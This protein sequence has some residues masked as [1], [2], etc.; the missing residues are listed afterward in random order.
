VLDGVAIIVGMVI[1]AGIFKTPSLV[2][3]NCASVSEVLFLWLAGG[4]FCLVG[5]LCYAELTSAYPHPGGDYH[6]LGRAF[7][8]VPAFLFAWSRIT[9]IQTGSIAMLAFLIGDYASEMG[10]L[11]PYSS[12][13]YAAITIIVLTGLNLLGIQ[14]GR[15]M[16]NLLTGAIVLG[17][18]TVVALGLLG[19]PGETVA[20]SAAPTAGGMTAG[21]VGKA[22]IFVLL[23]Y[24]GW[25]EIAYLSSEVRRARRNMVR[26]L[27]YGIA[28]ITAVYF[29]VNYV[30]F[31]A[32]GLQAVAASEAVAV[33]LVRAAL[34]ES[35]VSFISVLVIIAAL[36]TMNAVIITGSRTNYAFGRD[37]AFF[38]FLGRWHGKAN[39]PVN[40]LIFQGVA[41]LM[42]VV[43]G[44]G[45]R[46]GF[47]MMVEY[48]APVFWLFFF[49]VGMCLFVLRKKERAIVRPF[50]VPLYPLTPLIFCGVSLF[51]FYSSVA[52]TGKGG[53]MSLAVL[54]AGVPFLFVRRPEAEFG[55][56]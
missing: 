43:L 48:T 52:F 10:R 31:E 54:L 11:G 27:L 53:I 35:A 47:A 23:T 44:T 25:N 17:L 13:L 30:F 36:S 49:L 41:A 16:Q 2:A 18:V 1:G 32:L 12:S 37:F 7:G 28:V 21:G 9:V 51:M 34:G 56:A 19:A 8:S 20:D 26:I 42:L 50:R 3:A 5:A 4:A 29:C 45:T 15:W 40:A 33:D 22:L 24:G 14:Q 38:G 39:A 55:E 6:Y 46:S